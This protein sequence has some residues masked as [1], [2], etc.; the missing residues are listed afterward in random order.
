MQTEIGFGK[1]GNKCP[2]EAHEAVAVVKIGEREPVL[3][4]EVGHRDKNATAGAAPSILV[5]RWR[6]SDTP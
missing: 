3:E 4:D 6:C 2:I 5:D 1:M